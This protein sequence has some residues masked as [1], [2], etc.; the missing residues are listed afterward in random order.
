MKCQNC[1]HINQPT[2]ISCQCGYGY[3]SGPA[4]EARYWG[5]YSGCVGGASLEFF[6]RIM[7]FLSG[8]IGIVLFALMLYGFLYEA[9]HSSVAMAVTVT[10]KTVSHDGDYEISGFFEYSGG[11]AFVVPIP[12][13]SSMRLKLAAP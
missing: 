12:N 8:I 7:L 9:S 1:G 6:L 3:G 5:N 10:S 4:P 13:I 2:A 11:A